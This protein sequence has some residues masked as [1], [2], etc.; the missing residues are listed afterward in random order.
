MKKLFYTLMFL[1]TSTTLSAQDFALVYESP[2]TSHYLAIRDVSKISDGNMIVG[3]DLLSEAAPIAGIMKTDSQGNPL[4]SKKLEIPE[5]LAGCTFEVAENAEGNYYLWGLS[6]E[7]ETENMR[8]I[9]SEI[10]SEG[11]MLWSKEYDFGWN[12]TA[13]YTINQLDVLPSGEL[14]MMISVYGK[15]IVMRTNAGGEIVWGKISTMGPPEE[16]GKNPGFEWLGIPDDGGLCASKAMNDFSLLRFNNDGELL[17]GRAYQMGEYTHGKSIARAPNGNI[18]VSGFI[19]YIPHIMGISDEDGSILWVKT[20]NELSLGFFGKSH[21]TIDGENIYLD[22]TV[23]S[24][25]QYIVQISETGE[26]LQT[27]RSKYK[28]Y[29]YNK[30]E[31]IDENEAYFYGSMYAGAGTYAGMIFKTTD[32]FSESCIIGEWDAVTTTTFEDYAEVEFTPYASEFT[33]EEV[34]EIDLIDFPVSTKLACAFTSID[35]EKE[36]GNITVH[37]NPTTGNVTV[38]LP[39][40]LMNASYVVTDLSGKQVMADRVNSLQMQ[41]D[42]SV[43][44]QGQYLLVIQDNNHIVTKKIT[45]IE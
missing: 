42:L 44:A 11:D 35:S 19:D 7:V 15:V 13:A 40:D 2:T 24:G 18:L 25:R 8:A 29:D 21:I 36:I 1:C 9:L 22:F 10:S 31:L 20:F 33:E 34:I 38:I 41:I 37:P 45:V 6:K 5:S 43:L 16:G 26:V 4:W 32:I 3:F 23:T 17:W 27:R 30:I 14:Q 39:D 28:T 12:Y